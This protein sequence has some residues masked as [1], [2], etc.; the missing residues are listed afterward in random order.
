MDYRLLSQLDTMKIHTDIIDMLTY[1]LDGIIKLAAARNLAKNKLDSDLT[2][3][4]GTVKN[5]VKMSLSSKQALETMLYD[6]TQSVMPARQAVGE[7][8]NEITKHFQVLEAAMK[9]SALEVFSCLNPESIKTKCETKGSFLSMMT[10]A[11]YW[12]AYCSEFE[13]LLG[14]SS[15]QVEKNFKEQIAE[16]YNRKHH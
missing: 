13:R 11:K 14:T 10:K 15:K 9:E 12:D 3:F 4:K 2:V 1:M 5:P 6:T 7:A 16:A 8:I